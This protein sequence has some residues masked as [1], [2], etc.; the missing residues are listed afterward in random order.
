MICK[1]IYYD[2]YNEFSD[3]VTKSMRPQYNSSSL[4]LNCPHSN[5][6]VF[7]DSQLITTCLA[8]LKFVQSFL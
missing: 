1:K 4:T 8:C 7:K 6:I 3:A 5:L 2:K